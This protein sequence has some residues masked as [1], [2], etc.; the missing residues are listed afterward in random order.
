M[1][2]IKMFVIFSGQNQNTMSF[3]SLSVLIIC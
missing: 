2:E 1:K 3:Q